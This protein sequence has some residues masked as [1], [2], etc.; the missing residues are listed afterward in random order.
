MDTVIAEHGGIVLL[1]MY[2]G[3]YIMGELD[4]ESV[5]PGK[6]NLLNPR[7]FMMMPTMTGEVRAGFQAVC[8]FSEKARKSIL[9]DNAQIMV[10]VG[11]DELPKEMIN[12][13]NSQV[14]GIKIATPGEAA[15]IGGAKD[16]VV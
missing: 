3:D 9:I 4:A 8:A 14:T 10:V 15:A 16:I 2:N 12:G 7:M 1:R 11:E 13:Y 5:S 6:T